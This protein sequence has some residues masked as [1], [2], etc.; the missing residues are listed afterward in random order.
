MTCLAFR[1]VYLA[2]CMGRSSGSDAVVAQSIRR[3][4]W[5]WKFLNVLTYQAASWTPSH[6]ASLRTPV[7]LYTP[8]AYR[9]AGG[10]GGVQTPPSRNS[11]V[12]TKLNRIPSSV[13]NTS[14]TT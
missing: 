8:V 9:G 12:L 10:F 13:E 3:L 5:K 2:Y 4:L 6:P 14:V 11:E 1:V 7:I